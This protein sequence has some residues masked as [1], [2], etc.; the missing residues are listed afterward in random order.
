MDE[1]VCMLLIEWGLEDWIETFRDQGVDMKYLFELEDQDIKELISKVGPRSHFRKQLKQLKEE[2]NAIPGTYPFPVQTKQVQQNTTDEAE[3]LPSTSEVRDLKKLKRKLDEEESDEGR[4]TAK[5]PRRSVPKSSP[6]LMILSEVKNVM[7]H[8]LAK[9]RSEE[10]T[11]L[12][13]FLRNKI[14]DLETDKRELVGVFGETGA[15]KTSLINAVIE[16]RTL[17]PSGDIAACTSVMIKVEA[18]MSNTNYE[19]HIEFITKEEWKD[20]L[21]SINQYHGD[22]AEQTDDDDYQDVAEKMS[23]FYGEE[24][25]NKSYEQ[26]M[27]NKNFKE[28]PEF[29]QSTTKILACETAMELSAKIIKY[30][31]TDS[32][33]GACNGIKRWYWPLVKCVTVRV[34]HNSFLQ[35]VTLVDLPG[36]GDRNKS[37]DAMWKRIVGQCSTVWIV[38]EIKRAAT[39]KESWEI[40]KSVSSLIGNGGECSSIHFICTKSDIIGY[41]PDHSADAQASILERN[42][43]AKEAVRKQ[44]DKLNKTKIHFSDDCFKVFTVSSKEFLKQTVLSEENTEIPKLQDVLQKLNDRHSETLNYVSGAHGIL[45]LIQGAKLTK[46]PENNEDVYKEL[47]RNMVLHLDTVKKAMGEACQVFERHLSEGVEKSKRECEKM[48]HNFLFWGKNGGG[49]HRTLK[50]VVKHGGVHKTQK[51]KEINLNRKLTSFLTDSIDE[52]FRKTFPNERKGGPFNG[53]LN[54]FSL[55]TESLKQKYKDVELQLRFL[56]TEEDNIKVKLNARIRDQKKII[57]NSLTK[58]I[59]ELMEEC[60][61]TAAGFSGSGMLEKMRET[62]TKHVHESKDT[63]FMKA[64]DVMMNHFQSLRGEILETVKDT[65]KTSIDLSLRTDSCSI[66]D[67]STELVMVQK[68]YNDLENSSD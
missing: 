7:T 12:N 61:K 58:T 28:I 33:H 26:L 62:L 4:R 68:I 35:H 66:L 50:S 6:E 23:A 3:A 45:S 27:D 14:R 44:F 46:V 43:A 59:E 30:T 22:T 40:L 51:G 56:K 36:N 20:E 29:L 60:Y 53:T 38:T 18:N 64:K 37:R 2:Q 31:R 55:G 16:E 47:E 34:P 21:W 19:A 41:S 5:R 39:D 57:Y 9:L 52:E 32:N 25:E 8:V 65:L 15:G 67:V 42:T 49:F 10:K 24:W 17:L 1:F 54:K 11:K 48:L 13:E 63:M